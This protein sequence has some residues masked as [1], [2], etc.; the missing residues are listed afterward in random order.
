MSMFK[1]RLFGPGEPKL[2]SYHTTLDVFWSPRWRAP[3]S[4]YGGGCNSYV[5]RAAPYGFVT[6][7]G[8]KCSIVSING[9]GEARWE[10]RPFDVKYFE[11]R[12]A[13]DPT[14][15]E[16]PWE[17][18]DSYEAWLAFKHFEKHAGVKLQEV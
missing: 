16:R 2:T 11:E 12:L 17:C 7:D 15:I 18:S 8:R 6:G 10:V 1:T 9:I 5:L 14:S 3:D 4:S 13:Q